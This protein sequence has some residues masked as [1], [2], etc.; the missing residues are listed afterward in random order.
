MADRQNVLLIVVDQWRGD[1]LPVGCGGDIDLPNL[2]ALA[3]E[4]VLFNQHYCNASPCGPARMSLLT[5][6]YAMNHRVVQNGIPLRDGRTNLALEL[7]KH[8]ALSGLVGYTSWIPDPHSNSPDDPRFSMYGANMPG[9]VPVQSFEEPEFESYFA[10][11][12]SQGYDLPADPFQIWDNTVTADGIKPSPIASE[13]SDTRWMTDAAIDYVRGRGEEPW[14]LF[15]GYW[16]PHPP[17]S[18]SAPYH[19]F[20]DPGS[21]KKPNRA[22]TKEMEAASHP[23]L[24]HLMDSV[25]A[26][27]FL[28]GVEGLASD[29][30]MAAVDN[31]RAVY[32]GLM[33]EL[34]D[35]I[36]RLLNYLE[37]TG[38]KDDTLIIFTSD[39]GEMLGDHYL[40]GKES[41][42]DPTFHVPMIVRDPRELA[43]ATRGKS[44]D[45][46]TEHVDIMPTVLEYL[47]APIP[48]QCDGMPLAQ[49]L[50]GN[51]DGWREQ[52]FMEVDFRD[53]RTDRHLKLGVEV[54]D[55]GAAILRGSR[56]KYVH[57]SGFDP[58]LFDLEQDPGEFHNQAGNIDNRE[59]L[60]ASMSRM[61]DWRIAQADQTLTSVASS[62]RGLLGWPNYRSPGKGH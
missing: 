31:A 8:G 19:Q 47:G 29:L 32:R 23:I 1:Y 4:G 7:R 38:A 51:T 25:K 57:F 39:H 17:L 50:A 62:E 21:L 36:G 44:L 59:N 53:M 55:C 16:K 22:A 58:I 61:L 9:F 43:N 15:L 41:Y 34:D 46:F 24:S 48:R 2:A 13:H 10:Y 45:M 40:F 42:Y 49:L 56:Y 14:C 3:K 52:A 30:P 37:E 28:Q 18:A 26:G 60:I 6:Q 12:K 35:N 54:D 33:K 27:E 5:G 11:L 20:S